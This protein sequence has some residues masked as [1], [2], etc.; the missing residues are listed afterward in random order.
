MPLYSANVSA[1]ITAAEDLFEIQPAD[2]RPVFIHALYIDQSTETGDAEEEMLEWAIVRGNTSSGTGGTAAEFP[3]VVGDTASM[4]IEAGNVTTP[5]SGGT[6]EVMHR[7]AFN[8]RAGLIYIP[9]PETRIMSTQA[10]GYL[11]VRIL[12]TPGDSVTIKGTIY[13]EEI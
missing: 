3:L 4:V 10:Q 6:E 13:V 9:T 8:V 7:G 12:S 5:A 2:D 1:A 11:V